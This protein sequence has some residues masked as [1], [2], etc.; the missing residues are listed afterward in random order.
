MI[1]HIFGF[2]PGVKLLLTKYLMKMLND[3]PLPPVQI[4]EEPNL[5]HIHPDELASLRT[6][7]E[8]CNIPEE[9]DSECLQDIH[10]QEKVWYTEWYYS[11]DDDD[12]EEE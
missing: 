5:Y 4:T 12:E 2:V 6:Q 1:F 9:V 8:E 3:E 10:V 11:S 7:Q